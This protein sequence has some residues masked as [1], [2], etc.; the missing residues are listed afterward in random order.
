[1]LR[2]TERVARAWKR[3]AA[4]AAARLRSSGFRVKGSRV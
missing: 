4:A 3:R 2:V 1:M